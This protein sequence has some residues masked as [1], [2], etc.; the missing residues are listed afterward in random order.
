[1]DGKGTTCGTGVVKDGGSAM[2]L[3]AS[4]RGSVS[5]TTAGASSPESTRLPSVVVLGSRLC[6]RKRARA[7]YTAPVVFF[8][9]RSY[10]AASSSVPSFLACARAVVEKTSL[11]PPRADA[12]SSSRRVNAAL[13]CSRVAAVL[14][15]PVLCCGAPLEA[16]A[17]AAVAAPDEGRRA[18]RQAVQ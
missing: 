1:M 9:E 18:D 6:S 11:S 17:A 4:V 7:T 2:C 16:E 3:V 12:Q 10:R 13:S 8:P 5:A 15:F 14:S